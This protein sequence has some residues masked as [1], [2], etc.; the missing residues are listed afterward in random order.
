MHDCL[1]ATNAGFWDSDHDDH[2]GTGGCFGNLVCDGKVVQ[3]TGRHTA[4]FAIKGDYIYVGYL[5]PDWI[6][7]DESN[8]NN[9]DNDN[10]INSQNSNH[11]HN[12]IINKN[13]YNNIHGTRT[14]AASRSSVHLNSSVGDNID[15]RSGSPI[16]ATRETEGFHHRDSADSDAAGAAKEPVVQLVA[17][18]GWLVRSGKN[19]VAESMKQEDL[20]Q[21]QTGPQFAD[22]RS[23]RTA[24]GHDRA[25]R[26]VL[27]Q[28]DG[29]SWQRG[30][31][32]HA[33]AD[34]LIKH[35]VYNAINL[36]GGGSASWVMNGTLSNY[37][38]DE[39]TDATGEIMPDQFCERPVTTITCMHNKH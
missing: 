23:A 26:V 7:N 4:Q 24:L 36:D 19:Y 34:L 30:V 15:A 6:N 9:N 5:H 29:K 10:N 16:S 38:S 2:I 27:F 3:V 14:T 12:N 20:S 35:G 33:L 8:D 18:L 11:N 39:C 21:Q 31:S 17:G 28:V 25:G 37:V 13:K 32:L 1:V 22:M